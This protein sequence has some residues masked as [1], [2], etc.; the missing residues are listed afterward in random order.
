M[1]SATSAGAYA[2]PHARSRSGTTTRPEE[3]PMLVEQTLEKLG[4]MKLHGM[5]DYLRSFL[6]KTTDKEVSPTQLVGLLVDAEWLYRENKKLSSRLQHARLRQPASLEELDYSHSRGL[7][8]S[9]L[10]R[11]DPDLLSKSGPGEDH[12]KLGSFG[13]RKPGA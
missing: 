6:E 11:N 1:V 4:A 7:S 13:A 5:A 8:T 10:S 2:R 3:H 9:A 12:D